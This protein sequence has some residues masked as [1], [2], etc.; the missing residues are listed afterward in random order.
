M[1]TYYEILEVKQNATP[2]EI[3]AA[4][5]RLAMKYHPDRNPNDKNA[6]EKFKEI[7]EAYQALTNPSKNKK[8]SGNTTNTGNT[9]SKSTNT[10]DWFRRGWKNTNEGKKQEGFSGDDFYKMYNEMFRDRKKNYGGFNVEYEIFGNDKTHSSAYTKTETDN[11]IYVDFTYDLADLLKGV[12]IE[13]Q[14]GRKILCTNCHGRLRVCSACAGAYPH[15]NKCT[16]C[17]GSGVEKCDACNDV[18][19]SIL[20]KTISINL[21]IRKTPIKINTGD[22]GNN[23]AILKFHGMGHQDM[24]FAGKPITGDLYFRIQFRKTADDIHISSN[25]DIIQ[26]LELSFLDLLKGEIT[27]TAADGNTHNFNTQRI[28]KHGTA[29][30]T[31]PGAGIMVNTDNKMGNYIFKVRVEI[32]DFSKVSKSDRAT[33]AEILKK[34]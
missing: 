15:K 12:K 21:N 14:I 16:K 17:G 9:D 28:N 32:P 18:G 33:I 13:R 10:G 8:R 27:F 11:N 2:D 5:R 29:E 31:I 4:Y 7:S 26:F 24:D 6:E 23:Y 20:N 30:Y 3:K 1:A 22:D 19:Y 34:I 25:G